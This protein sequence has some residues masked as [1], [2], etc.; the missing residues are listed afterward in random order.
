MEFHKGWGEMT[1]EDVVYTM[2][3]VAA[4][5]SRGAFQGTFERLFGADGSGVAAVD[6]YTVTVDTVTPQFDFLINIVPQ[7]HAV[8]SKKNFVDE[9]GEVAQFQGVGTGPWNFVEASPGENWKF[10]EVEDHYRKTPE[11]AELVLWEMAEEATR[12]A[13]FETGNLDSFAMAFDSKAR[14][15]A[16]PGTRYMSV[17]NGA[18]ERI[19]L[20]P[21]HYVGMGRS[22][23]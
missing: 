18:I 14:V 13:N 12:V 6:D 23:L 5:D 8:V 19:G 7:S 1:A 3:E 22:R 9:G 16:V 20:H 4:G 17:P 2:Q 10:S 21:N 11:F 15:D